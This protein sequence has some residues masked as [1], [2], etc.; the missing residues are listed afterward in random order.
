MTNL[1]QFFVG[2]SCYFVSSEEVEWYILLEKSNNEI[3]MDRNVKYVLSKD[4]FC[5][6]LKRCDEN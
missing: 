3:H 4:Y 1:L 2:Y 6:F 5:I